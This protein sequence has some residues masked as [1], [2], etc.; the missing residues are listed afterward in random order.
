MGTTYDLITV[1]GGLGGAA[2]AK[3]MAERGARGLL[4]GRERRFG[5]RVRGEVMQPW[6]VGEARALG[7]EALLYDTCGH[8]L[9][10]SDLAFEGM[11]V[12]HRVDG[13]YADFFM[14][15]GPDAD[16]RRARALPL[17]AADQTRLPDVPFSGPEL[18]ADDEVRRRFFGE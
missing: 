14:E 1:G 4:G 17:I 3:A 6:G 8:A 12:A 5:D 9:R 11:C 2:L 10:W 7:L 16:A 18:P 13:W 15:I